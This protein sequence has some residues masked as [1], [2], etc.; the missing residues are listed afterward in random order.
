MI[1]T[2]LPVRSDEDFVILKPSKYSE[3]KKDS[4]EKLVELRDFVAKNAKELDQNASLVS[5]DEFAAKVL[6]DAMKKHI[7]LENWI[8]IRDRVLES[9]LKDYPMLVF[10]L[11]RNRLVQAD[12]HIRRSR[13]EYEDRRFDQA[14]KDGA[15][16]C[17]AML[18]IYY[19]K[20]FGKSPDRLN[21]E[22]L[23]SKMR[24]IIQEELGPEVFSDLEFI[25]KWRNTVSHP[26]EF[27]IV[28]DKQKALQV[29]ARAEMSIELFKNLLNPFSP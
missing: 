19:R 4:P 9:F 25:R 15:F 11:E 29:V 7:V 24:D 6:P 28:V 13:I 12:E 21:L 22:D 26:Q 16:A 23:L 5:I 8:T 3:A 27:E 20:N 1:L 2:F 18:N 17:E 14:I 10:A